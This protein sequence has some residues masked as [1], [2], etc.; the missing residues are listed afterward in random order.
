[1][2][3]TKRAGEAPVPRFQVL[4]SPPDRKKER[5]SGKRKKMRLFEKADHRRRDQK[6]AGFKKKFDSPGKKDQSGKTPY[7]STRWRKEGKGKGKTFRKPGS[8]KIF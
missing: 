3:M 8:G 4:A 5:R 1:M 7:G 6:N 2:G